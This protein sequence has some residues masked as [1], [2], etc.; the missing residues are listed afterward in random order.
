MS[1]GGLPPD[2]LVA[3]LRTMLLIRAFEEL[4]DELFAQGRVHGTMHLSVG[5]EAV[6]AGVCAALQPG[7]YILSTHRGHGHCLA[8]GADVR[9]MMAEFL[10]K[11]TGYCRGRGGSMHIADVA[12]GNLGANGIVAGGLP[13]ATGVGLSIRL[14]RSGQVCVAFFGDG[15]A[16]EGAFHEAL[17]LASIWE[18]PVLFVCENNQYAMSMP[19]G[20]AMRVARVSDRAAA[21]GMPGVTADGMDVV[22]VY[23]VATELVARA[24]QGGG[25][26]LLECVTYRY[27]GHSKSDRQ[28]YRAREEVEAWRARD[29]IDRLRARLLA[30]GVLSAAA[31]NQLAAEARAAVAAALAFA[32]ASPEPDPATL[33]E[34]VYA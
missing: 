34:G 33:L 30:A 27:R 23:T 11:A 3:L 14:R 20:R 24:R 25:P 19:V 17:N 21:Y 31:A 9:R 22:A 2:R 32:E 15:A 26:A 28:R 7:D 4:A 29:P 18:L 12:G 16:N 1:A 10:G 8:K 5:Q 13:I 6:A